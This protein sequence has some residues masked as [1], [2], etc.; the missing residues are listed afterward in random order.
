[1]E[2][3]LELKA[4]VKREKKNSSRAHYL[5]LYGTYVGSTFVTYSVIFF[6]SIAYHRIRGHCENKEI[7]RVDLFECDSLYFLL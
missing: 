6:S 4:H 1:M 2:G 7:D 3:A 5:R